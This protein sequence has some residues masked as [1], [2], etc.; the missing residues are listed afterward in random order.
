MFSR[1][2]WSGCCLL[3]RYKYDPCLQLQRE[4]LGLVIIC[5]IV[6][7]HTFYLDSLARL[8]L[9]LDSGPLNISLVA[10]EDLDTGRR[11]MFARPWSG[12]HHIAA[13][14]YDAGDFNLQLIFSKL[15]S[16]AAHKNPADNCWSWLA[17]IRPHNVH[18]SPNF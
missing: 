4:K 2:A 13:P 12:R 11:L 6:T 16:T 10:A 7:F 5:K 3:W 18:G 9:G 14:D 8:R 17:S 15:Q 1:P